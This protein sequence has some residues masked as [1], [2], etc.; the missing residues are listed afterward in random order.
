MRNV[1]RTTGHLAAGLAGAAMIAAAGAQSA[2]AFEPLAY[3]KHLA[4][5]CTVCH[6]RDG[7]N[8]GIPAI[9]GM[10]KDAIIGAMKSYQSGERTN[11]AM[12]SVA[13][14]LDDEQLD[15]LATYF[16]SLKPEK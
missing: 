11:E 1:M 4:K 10:N 2:A 5:E 8:A 3:G 6:R 14:S 13:Q 9:I 16:S 7:V 15:A 12:A